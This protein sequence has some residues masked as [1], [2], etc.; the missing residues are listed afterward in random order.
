MSDQ[1]IEGNIIEPAEILGEVEIQI[2][3]E[4][5]VPKAMRWAWNP[6]HANVAIVK[7][8]ALDQMMGAWDEKLGRDFRKQRRLSNFVPEDGFVNG[9]DG[10][11]DGTGAAENAVDAGRI[12]DKNP[13]DA[14]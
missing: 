10:N 9:E 14:S 6:P 4:S 7:R 12:S 3:H 13:T 1:P 5:G 11:V 2:E 8:E